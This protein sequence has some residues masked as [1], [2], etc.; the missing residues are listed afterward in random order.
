MVAAVYVECVTCGPGT[1]DP[2]ASFTAGDDTHDWG[3]VVPCPR[4]RSLCVPA[5]AAAPVP[6]PEGMPAV[7]ATPITALEA[8]R[9]LGAL[10]AADE[11]P[12][13]GERFDR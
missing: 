5:G 12:P 4:C 1:A 6:H 3:L 11:L 2:A 8:T 13:P 9:W 10:W 7:A